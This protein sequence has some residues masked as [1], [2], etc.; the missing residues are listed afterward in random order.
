VDLE[1]QSQH[2]DV[3]PAWRQLI[4]DRAAKLAARYPELMRL[5]VT[6]RRG[7]HHRSGIDEV[8]VV[9][10][11]PGRSLRAAKEEEDMT[12]ALR[13]ALV[14]I[15]REL[16]GYHEQRRHFGKVPGPRPRGTILRV[17]PERDY[18]FILTSDGQEVYFHHNALREIDFGTLP[19][20]LPVEFDLEQGERGPQAARVFPVGERLS[21]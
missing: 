21:T 4:E 7:R 6:L 14:S 17:F 18:G 5:H 20:G 2:V 9:A 15:E 1:I 19:V 11:V 8:D 16:R 10:N 3:A 12:A 13:A